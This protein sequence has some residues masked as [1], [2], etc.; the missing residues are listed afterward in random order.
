MKWL[1]KQTGGRPPH[2][3]GL[4]GQSHMTSTNFQYFRPPSQI[5]VQQVSNLPYYI[6]FLDQP[7]PLPVIADVICE[8]PPSVFLRIAAISSV[9]GRAMRAR[10]EITFANDLTL[11]SPKMPT[12]RNEFNSGF[13]TIP[14]H[15]ESAA[16][17]AVSSIMDGGGEARQS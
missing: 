7:L 2:E 3:G 15:G 8:C 13:A 6:F 12:F 9:D 5:T 11:P 1:R 16:A 14:I 17:A 10:G 4:W